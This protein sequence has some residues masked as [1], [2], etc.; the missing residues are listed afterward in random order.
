MNLQLTD[1]PAPH[2]ISQETSEQA[3]D[4]SIFETDLVLCEYQDCFNDEPGKLPNK[5]HLE[6]D[7]SV[8][9]VVQPPPPPSRKIP[10]ALLELARERMKEMREDGII[11]KEEDHTPGVPSM[12]VIDKRKAKDKDSPP[13]KDSARINVDSRDLNKALKRPHYPMVKTEEVGNRLSGAQNFTSLD[14]CS[15]YWQLQL[16]D[17]SSNLL[18]F[19]T[20]WGRYRFKRLPFGISVAPEIYQKEMDRLFEGCLWKL[21]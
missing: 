4:A 9:P 12:V 20:P 14:A 13:S 11:V 18:T 8:A 21:L 3:E 2:E 16:D 19:N 10:V 6:I 17:E 15:G 5:V 1:T 7:P